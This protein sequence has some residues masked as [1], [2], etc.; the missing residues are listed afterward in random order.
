MRILKLGNTGSVASA[1]TRAHP[2]FTQ[3]DIEE[4]SLL[5]DLPQESCIKFSRL[6][7]DIRHQT[8]KDI[9]A[10]LESESISPDSPELLV[11][12]ILL[13]AINNFDNSS[14]PPPIPEP[15]TPKIDKRR[16]PKSKETIMKMLETRKRNRLEKERIAQR[17]TVA[18]DYNNS[19]ALFV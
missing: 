11:S 12:S 1:F 19:V 2:P 3:D 17:T 16:L 13:E 14:H 4:L 18:M 6:P 5:L 7:L 9:L 15:I 10:G 8:F